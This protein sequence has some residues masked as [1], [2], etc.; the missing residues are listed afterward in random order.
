MVRVAGTFG[1]RVGFMLAEPTV[2]TS[3]DAR[4]S[5]A[6]KCVNAVLKLGEMINTGTRFSLNPSHQS[7]TTLNLKLGNFGLLKG[8]RCHTS[9][10]S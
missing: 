7:W 1:G 3:K 5:C 6:W 9:S 8:F 2:M 4:R 10:M